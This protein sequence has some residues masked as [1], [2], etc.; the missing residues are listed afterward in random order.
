VVVDFAKQKQNLMKRGRGAQNNPEY[1]VH[2]VE[3]TS[4][5]AAI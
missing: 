3:T 2:P 1:P 4:E 5:G